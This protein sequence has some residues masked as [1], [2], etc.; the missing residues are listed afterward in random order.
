VSS[1]RSTVVAAGAVGVVAGFL[2][3]LFGV[4]GGILIVPGL[5]LLLKMGQRLAHGT[6]LGA[7]LPIAVAGVAGYA[8]DHDVDWTAGLLIVAGAVVGAVIG[9]RLL[10]RL[11]GQALR[12][13][14]A[15][16]LLAT[17]IRLFVSTPSP[18]GR[19]PIEV[20]LALGL[21]AIGLVS[22]TIAGLLGVGGGIVIVP[23]LVVLFGVPGTVAKGTS[24][25]VIIPTAV[26][27]TVVNHRNGNVD[28]AV[29][30]AMGFAGAGAALGGERL[31]QVLSEHL[32]A[33]LFAILLVAVAARLFLTPARE[34]EPASAVTGSRSGSRRPPP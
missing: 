5:V 32:S 1:S 10:K 16:F 13:A 28:L 26:S 17:A 31:S 11:S 29:A 25:L 23:A 6:S 19:G 7:I 18:P 12:L 2:S 27:G 34:G 24:L 3:G 22:G 30:A 21:V 33:I 20:W 14:F 8:M 4:G 9:A 15:A